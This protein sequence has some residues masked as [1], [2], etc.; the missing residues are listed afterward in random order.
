ML[1]KTKSKWGD[2]SDFT[3]A[4]SGFL[5]PVAASSSTPSTRSFCLIVGTAAATARVYWSLWNAIP[6]DNALVRW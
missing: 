3:W 1:I 4:N 5:I 6:T 2:G